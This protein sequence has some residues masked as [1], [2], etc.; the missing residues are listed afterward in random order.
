MNSRWPL[1]LTFTLTLFLGGC[2]LADL[3][4]GHMLTGTP[5]QLAKEGRRLLQLA[6]W[7][8]DKS[9]S[10]D[11]FAGWTLETRDIW[12][13]GLI[14]RF[15]PLTDN[16]QDIVFTFELDGSAAA[17][18]FANG[19]RAGVTLGV[20]EAGEYTEIDGERTY[21]SVGKL[22]NYLEPV[23]DYFFW[24]QTLVNYPTVIYAGSAELG[25]SEYHKIFVSNGAVEPS[26][27]ADQYVVWL[28][29]SSLR[30]E[31]IEFTL[32]SLLKSYRGA[33]RY[34]DYRQV[35]G[36]QLPHRLTLLDGID[37]TDYSHQFVVTGM[38]FTMPQR[39]L[40]FALEIKPFDLDLGLNL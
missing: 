15:T 9:G 29:K 18:T 25:V 33:V 30:I 24:P 38:S 20:D 12:E 37:T 1:M 10:W 21:S 27:D 23:R 4:T 2:T 14:R 16:V 31:Y 39:E 19:K 35:E 13:S 17:M 3:R 26:A 36:I 11:D 7:R 34:S 40:G 32:R 6:V 8:Q 28:N 22:E 5:D